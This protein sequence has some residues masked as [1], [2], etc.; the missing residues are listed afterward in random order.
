MFLAKQ[1]LEY[2]KI[3]FL[4]KNVEVCG[5]LININNNAVLFNVVEGSF[6]EKGRPL[7]LI[8]KADLVNFHTHPLSSKSY[9]SAEDIISM[10]KMKKQRIEKEVVFTKWG[11]WVISSRK[12]DNFTEDK[13]ANALLRL[14]QFGDSLY[15]KTEKGRID[16]EKLDLDNI[17][18]FIYKN[19]REF[20]KFEL[21]IEFHTWG[22]ELLD[23]KT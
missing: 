21:K 16:S 11:I 7:C 18:E 6:D 12:K 17:K 5:N 14:T 4:P 9:P 19:E 10:M 8:P 23:L 13:K 3:N 1:L 15:R 2:I 20:H 22:V